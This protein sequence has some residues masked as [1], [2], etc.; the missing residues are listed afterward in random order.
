MTFVKDTPSG[1]VSGTTRRLA[2]GDT[3]TP[4]E[5]TTIHSEPILVPT[6]G[7]LTHL[8][9][10]RYAGC[11]I[12]NLHLRS[13]ARRHHEILAAGVHEIVVFHSAA[14]DMLP[15]QGE[16]PFAAVADP[17]RDLYTEFG[18]ESST[19][20]VLHPK[21]WTAP[22]HP[23]T[24]SVVVGAIRAGAPLFSTGGQSI[25]GLPADFLIGPD[26]QV[27]AAKYGRHAND[28]WSVDELLQ[29]AR[30]PSTGRREQRA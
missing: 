20:S 22:L 25:L 26:G 19:R 24:W 23:Q 13:V 29:L 2:A 9:F 17:D 4:R 12:C 21:A 6:P 27:L 30:T 15:Y 16:L 11:P 18:V 5:L 10:R 1:S 14:G 8:Q 28:Q 3:I 7:V